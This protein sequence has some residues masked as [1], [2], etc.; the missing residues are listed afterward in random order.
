MK[1]KPMRTPPPAHCN[2]WEKWS[3]GRASCSPGRMACTRCRW[4]TWQAAT[5]PRQLQAALLPHRRQLPRAGAAAC[6]ASLDACPAAGFQVLH[7]PE[8]AGPGCRS[9]AGIANTETDWW[10]L[11]HSLHARRVVWALGG[12]QLD[13]HR[14][15]V[16]CPRQ[17]HQ[18]CTCSLQYLQTRL[19]WSG[20]RRG[21][22]SRGCR[23]SGCC[24]R[25]STS[26]PRTAGMCVSRHPGQSPGSS[27][28]MEG[29]TASM[30][31]MVGAALQMHPA[32]P[33]SSP[34]L[35]EPV[36]SVV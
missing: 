6:A 33:D 30:H 31:L 2:S 19:G 32:E 7:V 26:Q 28:L 29:D 11:H 34:Q 13:V 20:S 12:M 27:L 25:A 16:A 1:A 24:R 36:V 8:E 15:L 21:R 35:G 9:F 10:R 23:P 14:L 5:C 18:L 3:Q 22:A 4:A 17:A